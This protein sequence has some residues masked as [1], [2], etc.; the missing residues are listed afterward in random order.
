MLHNEVNISLKKPTMTEV[1]ALLYIK[2]LGARETSSIINS[3]MINEIDMRSM[4][5]GGF[6][7]AGIMFTAGLA[8]YYFSKT[9]GR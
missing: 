9:D 2:R 8:I 4:V 5:K 7:G 1:E 6:I 3:D